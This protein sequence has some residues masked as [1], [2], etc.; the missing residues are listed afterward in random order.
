MHF[1]SKSGQNKATV[2]TGPNTALIFLQKP[3]ARLPKNV[4]VHV[5]MYP[6]V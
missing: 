5:R 3:I 2:V 4:H 1:G 6:H